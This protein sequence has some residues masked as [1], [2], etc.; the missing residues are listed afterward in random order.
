ML[1]IGLRLLEDHVV[2]A[3]ALYRAILRRLDLPQVRKS[4][5]LLL[6]NVGASHHFGLAA[7]SNDRL[8]FQLDEARLLTA[9]FGSGVV[10]GAGLVGHNLVNVLLLLEVLVHVLLAL[11]VVTARR[12]HHDL[13]HQLGANGHS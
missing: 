11:F 6:A 4:K 1:Q 9:G 13:A 5:H 12:L 8:L 7:D 10:A 2:L 3:S